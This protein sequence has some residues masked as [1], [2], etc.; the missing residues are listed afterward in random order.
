MADI[1]ITIDSGTSK[2][3]LT[4]GKYC[5]KNI[6]VT[7]EGGAD[8]SV[9][10][11]ILDRS[12][13]EITSDITNIGAYAFCECTKLVTVNLPKIKNTRI[14]SFQ[15]C[16]AL[17]NVNIPTAIGALA[18]SFQGCTSLQKISLPNLDT[19]Y[20][21]A[22]S[23][24]SNLET[25]ILPKEKLCVLLGI[26]AFDKTPIA[27]GTGYIYVPKSLVEEYKQ[28]TNWATYADQFRAI[29]DYP[30]ITGGAQI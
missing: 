11:S 29:E 18:S 24:C 15:N 6:L 8:D 27:S 1:P 12:V 25:I 10:N 5:D 9:L 4:E 23:G 16:K 20:F 26:N 3:L 19:I 21:L 28:A 14:S 30:E 2:R 17:I 13:T 22:F 7:A